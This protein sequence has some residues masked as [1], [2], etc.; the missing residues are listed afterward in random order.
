MS[1]EKVVEIQTRKLSDLV[2][3]AYQKVPF[4]RRLYKNAGVN[5]ESI[6]DIRKITRLPTVTKEDFAKSPLRERTAL[7]ID[8]SSCIQRTTSGSSGMPTTI[9]LDYNEVCYR[10]ALW[11]RKF[12]VYGLRPQHKACL[13][14]PGQGGSSLFSNP[15]GLLGIIVRRKIQELSLAADAR[16][17]LR[18]I[19]A[20]KPDLLAAPTSYFRSLIE[21]AKKEYQKLPPMKV[22]LPM[23]ENLDGF[24]K[25]LIADSFHADVF[26]TYGLGEVAGV[27]WECPAG[28]GLHINADS[29][30][31][32]F[33]KDG[34]PVGPGETGEVCITSLHNR[35][36]PI[37][38]YRVGDMV[39]P[40]GD[41]CPCGR[42]LPLI[43]NIEGRTLDYIITVDGHYISPSTIMLALEQVSGISQY[44]V[45]QRSDYSIEVLV[46][47][48][49]IKPEAVLQAVLER[50]TQLF[51]GTPINSRI[52]DAIETCEGGKFRIIESQL[53]EKN[54]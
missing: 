41:D 13:S 28:Q 18:L 53:N 42:G 46:K 47:T 31:V 44:K 7:D 27:A 2:N 15:R 32:E 49:E 22:A 24:A 35:V 14:I 40:L 23:G 34:E 48:E 12:W 50:C 10:A 17:N 37:L 9:C 51:R 26:E 36:T 25:K 33:L 11:L 16:K 38:R 6:S 45:I 30:I 4:Y 52:V 43:R 54:T 8:L 3:H 39:I 19:C 5:P 29:L 21:L 20:W 1:K